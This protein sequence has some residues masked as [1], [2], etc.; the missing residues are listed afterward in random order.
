MDK[1]KEAE[2]AAL[3]GQFCELDG[4]PKLDFSQ[5]LGE[6]RIVDLVA[7]RFD[8]GGKLFDA[9][10]RQPPHQKGKAQRL[11]LIQQDF[12]VA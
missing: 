9:G 10:S 4:R 6:P 2:S 11:E 7:P 1:S 12:A 3:T 8:H 5:Y